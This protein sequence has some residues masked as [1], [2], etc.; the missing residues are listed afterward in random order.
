MLEGGHALPAQLAL[1]CLLL[2]YLCS[3]QLSVHHTRVVG[4][5]DGRTY[6]SFT[7]SMGWIIFHSPT[8]CALG[9][10]P[11]PL[12]LITILSCLVP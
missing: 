1:T 12:G 2:L 11:P 5:K 3:G 4:L 8:S 10:P 9:L 7:V 6:S